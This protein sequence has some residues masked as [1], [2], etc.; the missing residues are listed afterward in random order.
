MDLM[1]DPDVHSR[2]RGPDFVSNGDETTT[3]DQLL[4]GR[5]SQLKAT[6]LSK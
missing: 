4:I 2:S 6:D 1:K 3:V 5:P